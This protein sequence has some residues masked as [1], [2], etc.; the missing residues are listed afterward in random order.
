MV[1]L[2]VTALDEANAVRPVPVCHVIER[3]LPAGLAAG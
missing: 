2:G 3:E 1:S